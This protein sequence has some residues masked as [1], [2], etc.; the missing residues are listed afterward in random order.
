M[1]FEDVTELINWTNPYMFYQHYLMKNWDPVDLP[2]IGVP[3]TFE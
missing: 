1:N 2:E 3:G